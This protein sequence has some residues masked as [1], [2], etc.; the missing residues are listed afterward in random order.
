MK[1]KVVMA[2]YLCD[3]G[4]C[5]SEGLRVGDLVLIV[6]SAILPDSVLLAHELC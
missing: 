2:D 4:S 5:S 6:T 3:G 1:A